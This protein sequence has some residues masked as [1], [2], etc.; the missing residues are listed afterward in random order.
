TFYGKKT[1]ITKQIG[2]A[3][4]PKLAEVL[5]KKLLMEVLK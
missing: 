5:A 4:P 3:V 1:S 2:N